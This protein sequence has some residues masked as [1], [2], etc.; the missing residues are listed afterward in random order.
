MLVDNIT[1]LLYYFRSLKFIICNFFSKNEM[2]LICVRLVKKIVILQP[3]F[4][5]KILPVKVVVHIRRK[6]SKS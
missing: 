1:W 6:K 2:V 3:K 5:D 4:K